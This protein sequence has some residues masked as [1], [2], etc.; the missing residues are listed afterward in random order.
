[1]W[2]VLDEREH[3]IEWAETEHGGIARGKV[4]SKGLVPSKVPGLAS[5]PIP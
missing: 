2:L 5:A 3:G 4:P 1:M